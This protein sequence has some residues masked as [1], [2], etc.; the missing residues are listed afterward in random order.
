MRLYVARHAWAGSFSTDPKKERERPLT[1]EGQATALAIAKAMKD[2]G[3]VPK[4]IFCSPFMRTTMT[5]DI[6]GKELGVQV[7]AIGDLAPNRPM[8]DSILGLIGSDNLKRVMLVVHKDNST[9]CMD[10]F[11]GDVPWIDLKMAEVRRVSMDRDSGAWV[12]KWCMKPSD[13]GLKDYGA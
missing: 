2:L 10:A 3:E 1:V 9:P 4:V 13:L 8:E 5:A 7:N 11:G 12:L 6:L